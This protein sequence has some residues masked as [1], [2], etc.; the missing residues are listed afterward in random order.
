MTAVHNLE[1]TYTEEYGS[2]IVT[3]YGLLEF[4]TYRSGLRI[5]LDAIQELSYTANLRNY[6]RIDYNGISVSL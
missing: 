2:C 3:V 1:T 5:G 6:L 4:L